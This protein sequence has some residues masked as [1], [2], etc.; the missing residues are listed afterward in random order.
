ME[1]NISMKNMD[2]GLNDFFI[3]VFQLNA[4][5]AIINQLNSHA[6]ESGLVLLT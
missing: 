5:K 1:I 6:K 4:P 2:H 3:S